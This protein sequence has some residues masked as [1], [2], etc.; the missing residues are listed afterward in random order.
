MFFSVL[1]RRNQLRQR[2]ILVHVSSLSV[3]AE[4][5]RPPP[6]SHCRVNDINA[7]FPAYLAVYVGT[8]MLQSM[9]KDFRAV[10]PLLC[11]RCAKEINRK[12]KKRNKAQ[13]A[14]FMIYSPTLRLE[15]L[16]LPA[17][18]QLPELLV[19]VSDGNEPVERKRVHR[20][21]GAQT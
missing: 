6:F 3:R 19:R 18:G 16:A 10:L 13:F 14:A 8:R 20:R 11:Q 1:I 21:F 4:R 7:Y 15:L 17:A 9:P 5:P 2:T 12:D